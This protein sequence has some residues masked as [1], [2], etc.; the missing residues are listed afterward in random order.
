MGLSKIRRK[1]AREGLKAFGK[2]DMVNRVYQTIKAGEA[3]CSV[4]LDKKKDIVLILGLLKLL[5]EILYILDRF[6]IDLVNH[7]SRLNLDIGRYT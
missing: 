1:K 7:I 6:W 3:I 4:P 5:S 2:E